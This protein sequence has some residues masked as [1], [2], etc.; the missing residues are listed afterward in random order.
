MVQKTFFVENEDELRAVNSKVLQF[1]EYNRAKSVLALVYANAFTRDA[2]KSF[3]KIIKEQ[4]PKATISGI[5]VITSQ[6]DWNRYGASVSFLFFDYTEIGIYQYSAHQYDEKAVIESFKNVIDSTKDLRVVL[7]YPVGTDMDFTMILE[8]IS[9]TSSDIVFFGALAGARDYEVGEGSFYSPENVEKQREEA[10]GMGHLEHL[11][12]GIGVCGTAEP[13]SICNDDI[14]DSGCVLVTMSSSMLQVMPRYV[15]G[16]KPLGIGHPV[17]ARIESDD[18]GNA[19]ISEIDCM[20]AAQ[21]YKKYL[22]VDVDEYFLDN[23]CEFP[24]IVDRHGTSIARVPLYSGE[25]GELYFSG[26]IRDGE[27]I[28]LSYVLP[29]EVFRASKAA[30]EEMAVFKP[31]A[32]IMSVCYNRFHYLKEREYQEIEYFKDVQADMLYGFGGYEILKGNDCGGILNSALISLGLKEAEFCNC[33]GQMIVSVNENREKKVKPIADRLLR[34]IDTSSHELEE[35]YAEAEAANQAKSTFLSNMSH[36]IRTPINAILGMNEMILRECKDESVIGYANNIQSASHSLLG[37][38]NDILDFSKINAGKMEIIPVEYELASVLND[39]INMVQKRA[40]DK[41]LRLLVNVDSN[42][43]HL[44]YGDEIRIKQV[45]TNILTNAVKYTENGGVV[46]GVTYESCTMDKKINLKIYVE[47]TGIGIKEEDLPKLF[48]TFERVDEERNRSIEGTGLGM[49]ITQ[50]LLELMGSKLEVKSDYGVGSLFSFELTQGVVD[51]TP[52]GDFESALKRSLNTRKEYHESFVAPEAKIL[53]VDDTEMNLTVM[54]NLLKMTQIQID[55]ALSGF[56]ALEMVKKSKYDI[57]FLDHR[58]PKMDGIECL[59]HIKEDTEGININTPVIALTANAVSGSREMYL[60]AGFDNY[61]T[62]PID[63]EALET[64]MSTLLPVSKVRAAKREE[65]KDGK[66]PEWLES[67]PFIQQDI[68]V[69]NCGDKESYLNAIK[70]F[71]DAFESNR[72]EIIKARGENRIADYTIKVHALKSS[73]RIIGAMKIGDLAEK[74]EAA[75]NQN[76]INEIN[77]H[78]DELINYYSSLCYMLMRHTKDEGKAVNK[79]LISKEKL[80]EAFMTIAEISQLFDYDTVTGV[81][82]NLGKY[83]VPE[84]E[85]DKIKALKKAVA[86]ADWDEIKRL[87]KG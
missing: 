29:N 33:K 12:S 69:K 21:L 44:L 82:E 43:P 8:E 77:A 86:N 59:Q 40:E 73:A 70:A 55:T 79:P 66:L 34:F 75:G 74:L 71:V 63:S 78:T 31:E 50:N 84:D 38:V 57:I 28:R 7:T 5:S 52:I 23:V 32:M 3:V 80:R 13:F 67:I 65:A 18:M 35:A 49:S 47:D 6:K 1:E 19:K 83:S 16:W 62:K 46:L 51:F 22:D 60:E 45:V 76:D 17:T 2:G 27:D 64:M 61:L 42:I 10:V 11:L 87:V 54:K 56:D 14:V 37:I 9:H 58:M 36:E 81:M 85:I 15:L 24:M 68:G 26:D 30:A 4:L 25:K 20:P 39:L 48:N 53:V 41:G 72:D